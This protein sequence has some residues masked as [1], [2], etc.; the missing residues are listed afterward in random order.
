MWAG[1]IPLPSGP[2]FAIADIARIAIDDAVSNPRIAFSHD[3]LVEM[4]LLYRN[5][6]AI[7][8]GTSRSRGLSIL[9]G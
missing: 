1:S 4:V 2:C 8:P 6:T 9:L 5:Q 3:Q 7:P